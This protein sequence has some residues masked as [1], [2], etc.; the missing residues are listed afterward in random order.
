MTGIY[1]NKKERVIFQINDEEVL[2]LKDSQL[3]QIANFLR[4]NQIKTLLFQRQKS[5]SDNLSF[6]LTNEK[7]QYLL[8]LI[9]LYK[10][11]LMIKEVFLSEYFK[12]KDFTV[13]SKI[14]IKKRGKNNY[15]L[16]SV[17]DC[18]WFNHIQKEKGI[19]LS[20]RD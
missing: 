12:K 2:F 16:L 9:P 13:P 19:G 8:K 17:N 7:K 14:K 15:L 18:H 6:V 3:G 11:K 10:R 20:G 4:E 1:Q 5:F